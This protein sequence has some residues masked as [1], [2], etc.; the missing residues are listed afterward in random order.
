M[1]ILFDAT[2]RQ[3]ST[4][5]RVRSWNA[6]LERLEARAVMNY[7]PLGAS[8]PDLVARGSNP[9]VAAYNGQI[10]V[11][12]DVSN[13]G[14]SSMV[15]PMNLVPGSISN[16]DAP[17]SILG[18][19]LSTNPR[20][21][22]TRAFKL[23]E[24]S[25]PLVRQNSTLNLTATFDMPTQ[26]PPRFPGNGGR[27]Y[28]FFRA[29]EGRTIQEIDLSNNISRGAQAVQLAVG[30]PELAVIAFEVPPVLSPGDVIDPN[31]KI[32]NFGTT[33]TSLQAPLTVQLVASTDDLFGPT[34]IILATYTIDSLPPLSTVPAR[35]SVLG[36]VTLDDP[37]NVRTA[38]GIQV[39]LPSDPSQ[40]FIGLIV[41]PLQQIRQIRD[42]DGPR[43]PFLE[44]LTNVGPPIHGQQ[45]AGQFRAPA[46]AS[47]LFPT[48]A[49]GL[50][51]SP[52]FPPSATGIDGSNPAFFQ[53]VAG[54]NQRPT[55]IAGR[56]ASGQANLPGRSVGRI[57]RL[58]G[59]PGGGR[60]L[61]GLS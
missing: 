39:Q 30:L 49:Y 45:P 31:F 19:Y 40:Y 38:G 1:R 56:R 11:Q 53:G 59:N 61:A 25:V 36:D 28:V 2:R 15:E 57:L 42:I 55:G 18:V 23:G 10:T 24:I 9:P 27:L 4:R 52:F 6:T 22:T 34:D 14:H 26:R 29:N 43:I 50:I 13:I 58:P 16:A 60:N 20:R 48:P 33:N 44:G 46:P 5:S 21:L 54:T 51:T 37:S 7:T 47:N 41:D 12:V 8:L 3:R 17:P 35:R 32:A